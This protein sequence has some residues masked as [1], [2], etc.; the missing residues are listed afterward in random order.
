M[1]CTHA[2]GTMTPFQTVYHAGCGTDA[3]HLG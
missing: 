3:A 1:P 2:E